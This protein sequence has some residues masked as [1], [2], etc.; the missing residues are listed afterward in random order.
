MRATT[1][2]LFFVGGVAMLGGIYDQL[3]GCTHKNPSRVYPAD[4]S[5]HDPIIQQLGHYVV[6]TDCGKEFPYNW[7]MMRIATKE[8]IKAAK[9]EIQKRIERERQRFDTHYV[10]DSRAISKL[11]RR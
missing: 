10:E 8:D 3:F 6:C 11:V 4:M 9:V 7:S 5:R 2:A 1:K